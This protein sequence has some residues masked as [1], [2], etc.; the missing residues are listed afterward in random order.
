MC[1]DILTSNSIPYG[2]MT[3]NVLL[4]FDRPII[5][6]GNKYLDQFDWT[7]AVTVF[8]PFKTSIFGSLVDLKYEIIK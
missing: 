5:Y 1:G 7:T 8:S 2:A 4:I 3:C 6:K